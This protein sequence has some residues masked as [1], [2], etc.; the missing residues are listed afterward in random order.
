M[1]DCHTIA[2]LR[3]R[4]RRRLPAPMFHYMDGGADDERSLARNTA[5]FDDHELVPRYLVDVA[6]LD[7]S[8]K[9]LGRSLALPFML[10]PTG[11]SRLFHHEKEIAVA[12]AA[13]AAGTL[14]TLS[15][16]ATTSLEDI[17]AATL[18]L[19]SDE[20]CGYVTGTILAVDGG[21]KT[22][23]WIQPPARLD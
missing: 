4:A 14:Y 3:R 13:A 20:H 19:L 18:A 16:L 12:R 15:T 11:M 2:D 5:A 22:H 10:S 17:A 9:V 6:E 7:L 21:L 23:N 1:N 8:T